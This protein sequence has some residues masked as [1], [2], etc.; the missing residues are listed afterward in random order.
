VITI[1]A[2]TVYNTEQV[3]LQDDA[4]TV[5]DLKPLPIKTLRKFMAVLETMSD[6]DKIKSEND[7]ISVMLELAT[8]C[9][10]KQAPKLVADQDALEEAL[11]MP[12]VYKIIEVCGGIKLND[13]N[14]LAA[15]T[16][17]ANAKVAGTT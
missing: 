6:K 16:G 14:L 13:P 3:I 12:T 7:G 4:A 8:L 10:A 9:I 5:L 11:D 2:S 17:I 15:A 1:P